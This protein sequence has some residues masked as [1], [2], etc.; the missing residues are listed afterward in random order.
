MQNRANSFGVNGNLD[1]RY[2]NKVENCGSPKLL[3]M[4]EEII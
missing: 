4:N 2:S 3:S 1:A